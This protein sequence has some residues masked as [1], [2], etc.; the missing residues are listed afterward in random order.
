VKDAPDGG[1][2]SDD[3]GEHFSWTTGAAW[4][5]A[6][7]DGDLDLLVTPYVRW[8]RATDVRMT[9]TGEE[10]AYAI[11]KL[12]EG[13]HPRLYVQEADGS[14]RDAATGAPTCS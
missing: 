14:F 2:W 12:Y 8:T 7:G 10:K 6:D 9:Q 1:K 13:D 11:P 3:E 5:D 4:F